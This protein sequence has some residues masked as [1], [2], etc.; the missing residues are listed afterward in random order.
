MARVVLPLVTA[1]DV[2][3]I[4]TLIFVRLPPLML[5]LRLK[6]LFR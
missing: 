5:V 1:A 4:A 3:A 2:V 6:L